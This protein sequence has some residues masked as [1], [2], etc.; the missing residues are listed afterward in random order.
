MITHTSKL[1]NLTFLN[2]KSFMN[3]LCETLLRRLLR[4]K[5]YKLGFFMLYGR[6]KELIITS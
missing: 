3:G 1:S 6:M 4:Y 2:K 5:S